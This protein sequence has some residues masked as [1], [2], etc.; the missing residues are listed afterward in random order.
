MANCG[1]AG[2]LLGNSD[3]SAIRW[4]GHSC[5]LVPLGLMPLGL[6]SGLLYYVT[7]SPS[8]QSFGVLLAPLWPMVTCYAQSPLVLSEEG[9]SLPNLPVGA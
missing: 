8:Q 4:Q 2:V 9:S 1:D 7:F 3:C 6:P 5:P